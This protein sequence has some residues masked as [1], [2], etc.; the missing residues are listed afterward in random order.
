VAEDASIGAADQKLARRIRDGDPTAEGQ[1]VERY[2][3]R[4]ELMI[5]SRT[6]DRELAADLV[7]EAMIALLQA[8]RAD[9]VAAADRLGAFAYGVARNLVNNHF[10][11]S[12]QAPQVPILPEMSVH[13]P[14][15]E[16]E[17]ADRRRLVRSELAALEP[18]DREI[19]Q[20]TLVEGLK[21]GEIANRLGMSAELVRTRKSRAIKRLTV[22]LQPAGDTN[23]TPITTYSKVRP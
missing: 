21:P 15:G 20:L 2:R 19:V 3:R 17:E 8:V 18:R 23:V 7:Q 14:I 13:D 10:R 16:I 11:A 5:L 4:V 9:R 22:R 12:G 1:L 6:R